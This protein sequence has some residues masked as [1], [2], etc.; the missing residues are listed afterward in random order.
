MMELHRRTT[1]PAPGG[2][3]TGW[4]L[5]PRSVGVVILAESFPLSHERKDGTLM[6]ALVDKVVEH[7]TTDPPAIFRTSSLWPVLALLL[8]AGVRTDRRVNWGRGTPLRLG[9]GRR[10]LGGGFVR[11]QRFQHR[12]R[13]TFPAGDSLLW[14]LVGFTIMAA[15]AGLR[16]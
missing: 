5:I 7:L 13:A 8:L 11:R 3:P 10:R 6:D 2:A 14:P 12:H 1:P 16:W 9:L 15:A 4:P